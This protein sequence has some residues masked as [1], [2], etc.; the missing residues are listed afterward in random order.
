MKK[1]F[2]TSGLVLFCD[3][4]WIG[5]T[6]PFCRILVSDMKAGQRSKHLSLSGGWIGFCLINKFML[7]IARCLLDD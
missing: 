3:N 6:L 4:A 1:S 2:I 7:L 5:E